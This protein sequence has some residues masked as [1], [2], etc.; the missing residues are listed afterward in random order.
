MVEVVIVT[1]M[2][3]S[4]RTT[5]LRALED[6]GY[7]CM[8]NLPV[9]LLPKVLELAGGAGPMQRVAVGIDAREPHF[10]DQAGST[11]DH[12][13]AQGL[14][15]RVL[16][17]DASDDTLIQRFSETRRRHPLD[18]DG[19]VRSAVH[20][21]RELLEDMRHRADVLADSSRFSVHELRDFVQRSFS[22][23][24]R[25]QMVV[26]LMSFGFKHGTPTE[27]D[28]M[29]DV[30]FLPNPYFVPGLRD[31]SGTHPLVASFVQAQEDTPLFVDR[32]VD[33]LDFLMPRYQR[34]GKAYLT[35]AI[36]CT[37]GRHRSVAVVELLATRLT[38]RGYD[39]KVSHRDCSLT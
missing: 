22:S 7:F 21:E 4:G 19:D 16:F 27:A 30:R 14:S 2:A 17:L 23:G 35:I 10:A 26:R 38:A 18:V 25:P 9:V 3:G 39:P 5:A 15:V 28:M 12:L 34:E 29:L 37:G 8:D 6:L 32:I 1:G 20:R 13:R 36:G 31:I 33:L 11:L 24:P